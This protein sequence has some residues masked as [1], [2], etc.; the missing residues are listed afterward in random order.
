MAALRHGL[1]KE[2]HRL[3]SLLPAGGTRAC[4]YGWPDYEE[5]SLVAAAA[6]AAAGVRV[7]L[8]AE[9]VDAAARYLALVDDDAGSVEIVQKNSLRGLRRASAAHI[10]L[11]THGLFGSPDLTAKKLVVNL[12]HGFGPKSND[13]SVFAATIPFSVMTCDTPQWGLAAARWL[14]QPEAPLLTT[15]NPRQVALRRPPSAEAFSRLGLEAGKY[16][17]WM[18]TYRSTNG[19]S[20]P[21]WRDAPGLSDRPAEGKGIDPTSAIARIAAD[22]G[23]E[24]VVKPH[25]L[26]A[27]RYERSGLRVLTTDQIFRAGMTLYQFIG[28]SAAMISDYS[29]VWVEYLDVD[30]PLILYCPDISD[31]VGGRG[32]SQPYMTDI[33]RDLIVE[34]TSDVAAFLEVIAEG[35]DWRP[36][37]RHG[38]RK[39][40]ELEPVLDSAGFA[41]VVLEEL[42]RHRGARS[43][44]HGARP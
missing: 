25:P 23:V 2:A 41:D 15:G 3:L 35:G 1:V 20:G 6:L 11:F 9:D 42:R 5:N 26:D 28:S 10:L 22:S 43:A 12:W 40:L 27:D 17:L 39:A 7:T 19:T 21:V 24:V 44:A 13:N 32:L 14:G 31:Y 37:E 8:L 29:S 30:R 33:A 36:D 34:H 4:V 18:P 16:V 38:L